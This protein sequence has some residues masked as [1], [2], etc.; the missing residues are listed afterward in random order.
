MEH[1]TDDLI[2]RCAK[3]GYEAMHTAICSSG[4]SS[5]HI[6]WENL[7]SRVLDLWRSVARAILAQSVHYVVIE[8]KFMCVDNGIEVPDGQEA[9]A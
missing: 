4:V 5:V 7:D 6:G 1:D 3:A 8:G 2:E 9:T